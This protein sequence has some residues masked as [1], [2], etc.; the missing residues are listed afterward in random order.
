TAPGAYPGRRCA[1][2][3]N[4][5]GLGLAWLSSQQLG[6]GVAAVESGVATE[7]DLLLKNTPIGSLDA[8]G[9][10][11]GAWAVFTKEPTEPGGA[12]SAWAMKLPDGVPF[13]VVDDPEDDVTEVRMVADPAGAL[14]AVT[15]MDGGVV[16]Y[17][18]KSG[19]AEPV[20]RLG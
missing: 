1:A 3:P 2:A 14:A 19:R 8:A 13:P 11:K 17:A 9:D 20:W 18:L 5:S 7:E 16:L 15:L 12:A 10:D 4:G 6:L